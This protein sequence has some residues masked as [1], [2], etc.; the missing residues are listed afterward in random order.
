MIGTPLL[1]WD[2]VSNQAIQNYHIFL[3]LLEVYL[4]VNHLQPNKMLHLEMLQ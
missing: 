2:T 3:T 4:D 1:Y